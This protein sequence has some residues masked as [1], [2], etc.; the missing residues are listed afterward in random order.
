MKFLR[1]PSSHRLFLAFLQ[2][3]VLILLL[4]LVLPLAIAEESAQR[5][6][7]GNWLVVGENDEQLVW[8]LHADG[9]GFAYGFHNGGRLSHGFAIN[10]KLQGDRVRVRTGASLRCRG[11][12]VAV[13]FTGWSPVTLDFS[14]V[15]GRHWLQDG[16]GLLSFQRRLGS[17]HTPRAGGKCP[18]LAG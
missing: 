17:W 13:A 18:D 14:I 11:G 6:W 16:G 4:F 1:H 12:V 7:A 15:D 2:V 3:Y 5:K 10:W 9:T 8:Q